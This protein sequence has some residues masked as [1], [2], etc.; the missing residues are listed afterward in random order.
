MS[1]AILPELAF[2]ESFFWPSD[3]PRYSE[4]AYRP[5]HDLLVGQWA[6]ESPEKIA[7]VEGSS[8]ITY[9]ELDELVQSI[10]QSIYTRAGGKVLAI[11]PGTTQMDAIALALASF[12]VGVPL[13][14]GP[15]LGGDGLSYSAGP[16]VAKLVSR[17]MTGTTSPPLDTTAFV[18]QRGGTLAR[19]SHRAFES[20]VQSLNA[21]LQLKKDNGLGVLQGE[22]PRDLLHVSAALSRGSSIVLGRQLSDLKS[23][24]GPL[25]LAADGPTIEAMSAS[26]IPDAVMESLGGNLE[27]VMSLEARSHRLPRFQKAT[28]IPFLNSFRLPETGVLTANHP[29]WPVASSIGIP[30]TNVEVRLLN[31]WNEV[32]LEAGATGKLA[33][34]GGFM[35]GLSYSEQAS[36]VGLITLKGLSKSGAGWLNTGAQA[37][38]DEN[39]LL[40][41]RS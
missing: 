17:E 6:R 29:S 5:L 21:F 15:A 13:S 33:V 1:K 34:N 39:G 38:M 40:Y 12:L 4:V 9:G 30:I 27:W 8:R 3:V 28:G 14:T 24:D 35:Q 26:G 19:V 2:W 18:H 22:G 37:E 25:Y 20:M 16:E 36:D 23:A 10:A 31:K 41:L 11:A 32:M 7:L